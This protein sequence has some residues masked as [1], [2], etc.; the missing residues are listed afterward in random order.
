MGEYHQTNLRK[1]GSNRLHCQKCLNLIRRYGCQ[2]EITSGRP[3]N[4]KNKTI[5]TIYN[6]SN[7]APPPNTPTHTHTEVHTAFYNSGLTKEHWKI[8]ERK[9]ELKSERKHITNMRNLR[10]P[11]RCKCYSFWNFMQRRL[12]VT[13][14]RFETTYRSHLLRVEQ[15]NNRTAWFLKFGLIGCPETSVTTNI[16]SISLGCVTSQKTN[17][18]LRE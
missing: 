17:I 13:C 8:T 10:F 15:Q 11:L 18:V 2:E 9:D 6:E 12:V 4:D 14:R 1:C 5:S 3:Q 16:N 7:N